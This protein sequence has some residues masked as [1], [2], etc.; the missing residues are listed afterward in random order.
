MDFLVEN[1]GLRVNGYGPLNG[2]SYAQL[3]R[4]EWA[5]ER[6]FIKFTQNRKKTDVVLVDYSDQ[7]DLYTSFM[8]Y[9]A[10]RLWPFQGKTHTKLLEWLKYQPDL[11]FL[12]EYATFKYFNLVTHSPN[13]NT[14]ARIIIVELRSQMAKQS[15]IIQQRFAQDNIKMTRI[16][17]NE[18]END[19][20]IDFLHY[21]LLETFTG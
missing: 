13:Y 11:S 12:L 10:D 20:P 17:H 4:L 2:L 18:Q 7:F 6:R 5:M 15:N 9:L 1:N 16:K 8:V 3:T 19:A 14:I 21:Q